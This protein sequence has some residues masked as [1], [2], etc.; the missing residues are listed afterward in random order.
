MR[1]KLLGASGLRVSELALGTMTFGE[2]WGW[3]ASKQE[4]KRIFDAFAAAGGN[5]IDTACNYT[6]G[7]SERFVGEFIE[8]DR[9]RYVVA[10]KYTLRP[11]AA[12][13]NDPNRGG[14]HRK[15]LQREVEASLERLGTEY[16]DLLYVHMWDYMTPVEEV[17]RGLND[18]VRAGKIL[19]Y[20]FSDTPAYV[21]A[22]ANMYARCHGMAPVIATQVPYSLRGRDAER[23]IM[24]YAR[25][26]D[27]AVTT[28]GM[29]GG[30]V[31][32]GKYRDPKATTRYEDVP[33]DALDLADEVVELAKEIGRSPAQVAINWVKGRQDKAQIIP[34]L[35]ART[36]KQILD[37]LGVLEFELSE[38]QRN[39]LEALTDFSLG[40]PRSFLTGENVLNLV[41][42]ETAGLIDNHRA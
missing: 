42:G 11:N 5:F 25:Q 23:E 16:I 14:N 31:L 12:Q 41:H 27:V 34:I 39:R 1:Y 37:N 28:W 35:G 3:G 21:L 24:P 9:D 17:M 15:N 30:G 8:S 2:D 32:T 38:E 33:E 29:L 20:G 6:E 4:S 22:Q 40:F 10:T 18:L 36:E 13:N 7:T 19:Y 26:D